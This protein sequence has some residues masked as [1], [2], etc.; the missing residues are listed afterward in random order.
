MVTEL[1][2]PLVAGE[3]VVGLRGEL[4]GSPPSLGR[5]NWLTRD[6]SMLSSVVRA[7][8]PLKSRLSSLHSLLSSHRDGWLVVCFSSRSLRRQRRGERAPQ[9]VTEHTIHHM[10]PLRF[11]AN[12]RA[13]T[14][15]LQKCCR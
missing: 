7:L 1:G 13:E 9:R 6:S 3:V 5:L 2:I 15:P 14:E 12:M 11:N 8:L 4:S 10:S